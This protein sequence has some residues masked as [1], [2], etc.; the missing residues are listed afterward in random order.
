MLSASFLLYLKRPDG[1]KQ[2]GLFRQGFSNEE[3]SDS[4]TT[5]PVPTGVPVTKIESSTLTMDRWLLG[6]LGSD[7]HVTW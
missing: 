7:S 4:V 2:Y 3:P 1:E 6:S 5:P